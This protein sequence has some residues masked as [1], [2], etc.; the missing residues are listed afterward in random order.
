[1]AA[2]GTKTPID[3]GL[4]ERVALGIRYAVTGKGTWF[5]PSEPIAPQAPETV[6]GR[7]FDFPFA[8]NT[9]WR[10]RGESG[11]TGI[12]FQA[13]RRAADPGQGGLDLLRLAIETRKD[14]LA[15]QKWT[16]KG[17]DGKD[18]GDP[19]KEIAM[20]LKRPDGVTRFPV[21]ARQVLEDHLVCDN[22]TI[23]PRPTASGLPVFEIMDGDTIKLLLDETGRRPLPPSPAFQQ[24]L[25]GMVANDYTQDELVY[26]PFNL[27]SNRIYGMSR[28]EQ[29]VGIVNLAL[30]R[31]L[32]MVDFY[33]AGNIPEIII[34][35]PTEWSSAMVRDIQEWWDGFMEGNQAQKRKAKFIPGGMT[36]YPLKDPKLTDPLD[37]WLARVIC[38]AFSLPPS[39]LVKEVNRATAETAKETGLQEGL[40]PLKGW[41]KDLIDD[42]LERY[43]GVTDLEFAWVDEE[44]TDPK[45]KA[46]VAKTLTG[47]P[48]MTVNEARERFYNLDPLDAAALAELNPPPMPAFGGGNLGGPDAPG[49]PGSDKPQGEEKGNG[50]ASAPDLPPASGDKKEPTE[51]VV[52]AAV[53]AAVERMR[54]AGGPRAIPRN[55]AAVR[56]SAKR[57]KAAFGRY[58]KAQKQA[59]VNA[60]RD[61]DT[62][63][64][65]KMDQDSFL[66]LW[67]SIQDPELK[68]KLAAEIIEVLEDMGIDGVEAA[69]FQV[70]EWMPT[71]A[72][73]D[74]MLS[75]ANDRAVEYAGERAAELVGM[76][77]DPETGEWKENPNPEW[78]IDDSTRDAIQGLVTQAEEEGWSNDQLADAIGDATAF[79]ESRAEMVARTET[80][81]AD[82]AGNLEGYKASGVVQGKEWLMAQDEVCEECQLLHGVVVPLD[83]PFPGEGAD[84]PPLHPNCRCD[85]LPVL[86]D[87]EAM[88][89]A[90]RSGAI[91]R[92]ALARV[93]RAMAQVVEKAQPKQTPTKQ[94]KFNLDQHGRI[95]GATITEG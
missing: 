70:R 85:V 41:F 73:L 27:R 87:P 67:D 5:G 86:I 65:A 58:F 81:F 22:V 8:A 92:A 78:A 54:K 12:T 24:I 38:W 9:V 48:I 49:K 50:S 64:V 14:Q 1:M 59:L 77:K 79:D 53:D 3:L 20:R 60:V 25:K 29:V 51:K 28:A 84:G 72:E 19:A 2:E 71:E 43:W 80:A 4:I 16:I 21:W 39:A 47:K 88:E 93:D 91:T 95:V 33:T 46:D 68:Q 75:Q 63:K 23:Y 36:P 94:V 15:A 26:A 31:H 74:A 56:T 30:K 55:R 10:P 66:E 34:A 45:V 89:E 76:K 90:A 18:G 42:L 17:K 57:L 52:K 6:R 69:L 62:G 7:A 44:I 35:T 32:H 40:E 61:R 83:E 13:L 11:E 82:V 37:E